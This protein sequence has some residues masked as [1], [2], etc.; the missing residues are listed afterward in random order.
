M[1]AAACAA[2]AENASLVAFAKGHTIVYNQDFL[3]SRGRGALRV[4]PSN[5]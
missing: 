1:V 3:V 4:A 5:V 2:V